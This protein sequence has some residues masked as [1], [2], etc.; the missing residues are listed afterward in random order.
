MIDRQEIARRLAFNMMRYSGVS[1]VLSPVFSGIGAVLML[2]RVTGR[3]NDLPGYNRHLSVTPEFL[4]SVLSMLREERYDLIAMSEIKG[5]IERPDLERP[6]V[7]VT[8]DDGYRDNLQE[9]LPVFEKHD[10]P[11]TIYVAPGLTDGEV[12]LWWEVLE[13]LVSSA[14]SLSFGEGSKTVS[15]DCASQ[16]Q[17]AEAYCVLSEKLTKNIPEDCQQDFIAELAANA[18][19]DARGYCRDL[20]M[21]WQEIS[22][23]A[24]HRLCSIGA[25]TVNHFNLRRLTREH[26][27]REMV[28]GKIRLEAE[29]GFKVDHFAYPY[30]YEEAVGLRETELAAEAGFETAV[31]TRHGVVHRAHASHMTA[32][33]RISVNGRYQDIAHI[34]TMLSG[35]TSVL[36]SRGKRVVTV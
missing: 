3:P 24:A 22:T 29:L 26:A 33:P 10:T 8:L 32:L 7:A 34:R 18:G 5:R 9:A 25:H 20:L 31:T 13:K 21:N 28:E 35:V 4:D 15:L 17:K 14:R 12:T 1:R 36:A 11:F 16:K 2:H 23:I 30:G 6:F 19:F 27:L